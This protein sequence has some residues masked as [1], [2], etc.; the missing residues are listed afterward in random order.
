MMFDCL[1]YKGADLRGIIKL[2]ERLKNMETISKMFK[3]EPFMI[4]VYL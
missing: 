2:S 4:M 1:Y 3:F